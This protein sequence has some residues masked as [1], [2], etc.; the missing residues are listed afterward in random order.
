MFSRHIYV[1]RVC[2]YNVNFKLCLYLK[3]ESHFVPSNPFDRVTRVALSLIFFSQLP[4]SW[5]RI[6]RL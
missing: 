5:R 3:V 4:K 2:V 6:I 1:I